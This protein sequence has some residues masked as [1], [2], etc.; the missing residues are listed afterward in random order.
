MS[1][2]MGKEEMETPQIHHVSAGAILGP[3]APSN[4]QCPTAQK[5]VGN[6]R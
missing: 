6:Q 2:V 4:V 5:I 3:L 1:T